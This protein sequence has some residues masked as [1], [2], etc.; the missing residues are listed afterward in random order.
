MAAAG[1]AAAG[2]EAESLR[3]ARSRYFAASGFPPDG[4]YSA[5]WVK[6][7][8][9]PL[10]FAFPNTAARVRAVRFHDLHHVVTGY[11]TD[12]V[13]EGEIAAWE[14]ASGCAGFAAA[15]FLNL[16]AMGLGLVRAPFAVW[17]AFA[18]GRR[19]RN[20]YRRHLDD[21]LLAARV[22][23]VRAE[24]GLAAAPGPATPADRLAFGGWAVAALGVFAATAALLSAPL[25]LAL[26]ALL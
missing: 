18:R 12:L 8:L 25:W 9:G 19:T 20:L 10:P 23:D 11:A 21:A 14:L 2:D 26:R 6:V 13:G 5:R 24:L 4:G 17:R 3:E 15:W 22:G 1:A 16:E 7:A